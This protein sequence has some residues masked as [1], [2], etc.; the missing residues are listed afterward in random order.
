MYADSHF[1]IVQCFRMCGGLSEEAFPREYAFCTCAHEPDEF[2]EQERLCRMMQES[3]RICVPAYGLH[4]QQP[5]LG[6]MD[7]LEGLLAEK[8]IR[9]VGEC[10]F[11]F[12]TQEFKENSEAQNK[13]WNFCI[14]AAA[15]FGVP[16]V[17]HNRKALDLMF[18]DAAKL[19]R[20]PAVI[21]HSFAFTSRE[22]QSLLNHGINAYFSFGKPLI[23]GNKKSIDCV[24]NLPPERLL[25]ETDAPFQT[26]KGQTV[27]FPSEIELV[28]KKAAELRSAD[29]EELAA[30]AY[31]NFKIAFGL[32]LE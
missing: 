19:S 16:A 6:G 7:F 22:A 30:I 20:L 12:F 9:A 14:A 31:R 15:R 10:G 17:V 8:R 4:P 3:D 21:F 11:D 18:R 24:K 5:E 25:F 32:P 2:L 27:T 29:C 13:A 1:H 26:L 23:N 28:Y